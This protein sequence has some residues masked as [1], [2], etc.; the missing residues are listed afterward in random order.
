[1]SVEGA[2]TPNGAS[3]DLYSRNKDINKQELTVT[4]MSQR[5]PEKDLTG[6]VPGDNTVAEEYIIINNTTAIRDFGSVRI[7]ANLVGQPLK[8]GPEATSTIKVSMEDLKNKFKARGALT[9][10]DDYVGVKKAT[11]EKSKEAERDSSEELEQ[12]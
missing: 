2:N 7:G 11:L 1:M 6:V 8:A 10:D 4:D 9:F 5:D 3:K 12:D